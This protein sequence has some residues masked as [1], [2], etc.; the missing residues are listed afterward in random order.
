MD[1]LNAITLSAPTGFWHTIILGLENAIGDYA[2]ALILITAIIKLIMVPFDFL[3]KYTSKKTA[4]KQAEI[5]PEL[6]K[7][8]KKYANDKAMLNQKTNE[9]YK[10]NNVNLMGS[11]FGM[12]IYFVLTMVVFWT[13]FGALNTISAYKI[14][15]QFLQVRKE[16]FATYDIN[17]DELGE[18]QT[19]KAVLDEK[20][21]TLDDT[22]KA[23]LQ[24]SANEKAI[25]KYNETKSGFLWIENIWRADTTTSPVMDYDSFISQVRLS[26][27]EL[28]QEEYD[29][30]ITPIKDVAKKNNG[31]FVLALLA[32]TLSYLSTVLNNLVSKVRSKKKGMELS[33]ANQTNK[34]L[35]FL[36]PAI[37]GIFTLF[38]N[39]AFGLYIVAGSVISLITGPLITMFV[40]ML[41]FDAIRKENDR[42]MASY[43]RK[44][45]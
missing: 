9:L 22:T 17:V 43:D 26:E 27:T 15:D 11:C 38:Y 19:A 33:M 2:L 35:T 37:M 29:I 41:E 13:L 44:R 30:V 25:A 45:K 36:M 21:L 16:Y 7:I 3:N 34:L 10:K 39:A 23:E 40:D 8:N 14:G 18:G 4:R 24:A 32:A 5:K 6:D 31:Y 12:L 1:I 20:L 42:V 28:T